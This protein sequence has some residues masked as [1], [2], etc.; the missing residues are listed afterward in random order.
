MFF[1]EL[2]LPY[3]DI[4]LELFQKIEKSIAQIA[5]FLVRSV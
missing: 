2:F 3:I 5:H 4:T 1:Q